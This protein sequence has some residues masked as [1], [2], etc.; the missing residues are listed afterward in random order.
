MENFIKIIDQPLVYRTK[1]Q[2]ENISR[3]LGFDSVHKQRKLLA[4]TIKNYIG[5]GGFLFA[6]CSAT[7][8]FDIALATQNTDAAH[9]VFDESPVDEDL[10]KN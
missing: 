5:S 3:D 9:E 4:Q 6:M 7:D 2:Y 1:K 8:S 10:Q